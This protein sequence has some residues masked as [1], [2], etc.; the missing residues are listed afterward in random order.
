M[1]RDDETVMAFTMRRLRRSLREEVIEEC[2]NKAAEKSAILPNQHD[3]HRGYACGRGD[4][5]IAIRALKS[6]G[7]GDGP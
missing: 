1:K 7:A 2:A 3:F 5:A 6:T 4:A